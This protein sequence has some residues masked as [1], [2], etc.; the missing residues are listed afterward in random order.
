MSLLV[1]RRLLLVIAP[2]F[3]GDASIVRKINIVGCAGI[4]CCSGD[5]QAGFADD[6]SPEK[7]ETENRVASLNGA[8]RGCKTPA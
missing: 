3:Q 4:G 2:E 6:K 7:T 1:N 8:M 5:G